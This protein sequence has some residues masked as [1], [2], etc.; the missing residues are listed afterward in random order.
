M[1]GMRRLRQRRAAAFVLPAA[2]SLCLGW[3][4]LKGSPGALLRRSSVV[5][6]L[7]KTSGFQ[8]DSAGHWVMLPGG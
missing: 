1:R 7:P 4:L 2:I 3:Q 8:V 6:R 5:G